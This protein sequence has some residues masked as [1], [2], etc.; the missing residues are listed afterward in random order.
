MYEEISEISGPVVKLL[1][2]VQ[3][4]PMVSARTLSCVGSTSV[5]MTVRNNESHNCSSK[6]ATSYEAAIDAS[7]SMAANNFNTSKRF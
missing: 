3:E 7:N 5:G 6:A 1:L 4:M 2:L